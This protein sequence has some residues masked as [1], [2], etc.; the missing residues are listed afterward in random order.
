LSASIL[1]LSSTNSSQVL[2]T[3]R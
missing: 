2:Y 3:G 1:V